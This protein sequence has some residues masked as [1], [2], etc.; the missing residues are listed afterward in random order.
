MAPDRGRNLSDVVEQ[1]PPGA[2]TACAGPPRREG[3]PRTISMIVLETGHYYQVRINPHPQECHRNLEAVDSML[4]VRAAPPD[5][6]TPLP[7]NQPPN[8]LT[9]VVSGEAGTWHPCHALYCL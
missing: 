2:G 1:Y 8:P 9:A 5:G 4:P 7:Y 6:P 3:E